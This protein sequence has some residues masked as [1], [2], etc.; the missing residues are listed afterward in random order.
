MFVPK[1]LISVFVVAILLF[2]T[3]AGAAINKIEKTPELETQ[4]EPID[5]TPLNEEPAGFIFALALV[6][7]Y[8][9]TGNGHATCYFIKVVVTDSNGNEVRSGRTGM[10]TGIRFFWGLKFGEEYTFTAVEIGTTTHPKRT[11]T[12][13]SLFNSVDIPVN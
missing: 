6:R 5:E 9:N 10:F 3:N 7:V 11:I 8:E 4:T 1:I 2:S 12:I 13:N